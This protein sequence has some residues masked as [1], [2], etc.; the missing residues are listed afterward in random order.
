[1]PPFLVKCKCFSKW[2]QLSFFSGDKPNVNYGL[3]DFLR[4]TDLFRLWVFRLAV[5][6]SSAYYNFF[7]E[8]SNVS[9]SIIP[10]V[11][12][13]LLLD[14][15]DSYFSAIT[16]FFLLTF[17]ILVFLFFESSNLI[18]FYYAL[19]SCLLRTFGFCLTFSTFHNPYFFLKASIKPYFY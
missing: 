19:D 13:S 12:T 1:M 14:E 4:A 16:L 3:P 11:V 17:K 18:K 7:S 9:S 5:H 8:S 2:S 6:L 10:S 15:D